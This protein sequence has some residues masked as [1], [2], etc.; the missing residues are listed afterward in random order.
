MRKVITA[1]LCF[2][3]FI[4]VVLEG[5]WHKR[6]GKPFAWPKCNRCGSYLDGRFNCPNDCEKP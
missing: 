4:L 3:L 5:K 2:P 1:I 6:F